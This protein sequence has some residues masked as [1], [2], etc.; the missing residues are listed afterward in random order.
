[1]A[2]L[3]NGWSA[4]QRAAAQYEQAL[5]K[6][7]SN[8]GA[9]LAQSSLRDANSKLVLVERALTLKDGLPDRPWYEHQIYAPGLY[10]G[11]GVK[12]LPGVRESI[13]QKQWTEADAQIARV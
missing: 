5:G 11:Y 2:P 10:T 9:A 7:A 1:F 13:E 8:G 6:A 3:E 12:T 4:L